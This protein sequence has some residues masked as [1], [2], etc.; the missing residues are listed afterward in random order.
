MVSFRMWLAP[1]YAV[2]N[3]F[4]GILWAMG[5]T[6]ILIG[7]LNIMTQMMSVILVGLGIDFA[8][9]II[10]GFTE[11]RRQGK[12][13]NEALEI[14][15]NKNG[16]GIITGG[17]TTAFAFLTMMI[18]SSQGMKEM[19]LVTGLG[20]I[21]MLVETFLVLPIFLVISER[22]KEKKGA[23]I[24]EQDITFRSLGATSI[25]LSK[26]YLFTLIGAVAATIL[27]LLSAGKITFDQ[28]YLHMEPKGLTSIALM[29]TVID[30]FNLTMDYALVLAETPEKCEELAKK[31][32]NLTTVALVEDISQYIP[33]KKEQKSRSP[34]I[35]KIKET[36]LSSTVHLK[37]NKAEIGSLSHEIERL[38]WNVLELQD[39]A[40]IGGQDKVDKA[41]ALLTGS[42]DDSSSVNRIANLSKF[43]LK[44]PDKSARNLSSFQ[45]VFAH[46]FKKTVAN[47]ASTDEITIKTLPVPD[48]IIER[49]A[50][51]DTSLFLITI[52][53]A[54]NMWTD[55][56]FLDNFV[57]DIKSISKRVT[58]MP[59]IFQT[60]MKVIGR[61]GRN[62]L[63]LTV[64]VVFLLLLLDFRSVRD[65]L[66]AMLPLT[67]GIIWMVGLMHLAGMQFTVLKAKVQFTLYLPAQ[68]RPYFSRL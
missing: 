25:F 14:T 15:F 30:K 35:K 17:I 61:D 62:A 10:S 28:N 36:I 48:Q 7:T 33:S 37:L 54:S 46:Y 45:Q 67:V 1:I 24:K 32:R 22:K 64:F 40:Y 19:G 31:Y 27:L 5:L 21:A 44:N 65:A 12:S 53:P 59:P 6:S 38:N 20:L 11:W 3:L 8:I 4:I 18:S 47:M 58:G 39:M 55:R 29:D 68:E 52:Y 51:N 41:C 56:V 34:L 43:I 16:K 13:I 9:H 49:Y 66:I 23:I 63:Y 57:K 60:L 42:P 50:N 2:I 26:K